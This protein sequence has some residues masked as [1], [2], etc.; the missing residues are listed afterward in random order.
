[1]WTLSGNI[2][3]VI[4]SIIILTAILITTACYFNKRPE[5]SL[6]SLAAGAFIGIIL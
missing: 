5:P 3:K 4:L 2:K 6:V 1:M